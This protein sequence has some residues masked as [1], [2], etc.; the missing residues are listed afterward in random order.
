MK[1]NIIILTALACSLLSFKVIHDIFSDVGTTIDEI[2]KVTLT[3]ISKKDFNMPY[4]TYSIKTA[5]KKLPAGVREATMLSI[6][7]VIR[8]YVESPDFKKDYESY[9]DKTFHKTNVKDNA[10]KRS[11]QKERQIAETIKSLDNDQYFEITASQVDGQLELTKS[12][13]QMMKEM[14]NMDVGMK[15]EDLEQKLKDYSLLKQLKDKDKEAFK[16][17]Y[18]E[19]EANERMKNSLANDA[20]REKEE[21][22]KI[23]ELK[24][25]KSIIRKQLQQFL[26]QSANIDF[27]AELVTKGNKMYFANPAY[28]KKG[29]DWKLYYRCGSEAVSGARKFAQSWLNDLK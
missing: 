6:G 22:A 16:K 19:V 2:K 11:E 17:K 29:Y 25:Y 21:L 18:A 5:C 28:E 23:E 10:A 4:Y 14:P 13:L 15:K 8:E 26:K 24:D 9:L 1:R 12:Y 20:N 3:Q 27:N 7:K